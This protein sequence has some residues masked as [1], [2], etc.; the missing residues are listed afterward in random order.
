MSHANKSSASIA[1]LLLVAAMP[2]VALATPGGDPLVGFGRDVLT[3]LSGTLGPVVFG[4]GLAIA[5]IA[6]IMGSR[7]GLQKAVWAIVGGALLFGVDSVINFVSA[8]SR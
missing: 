8:H 2:Q 1:C 6:L 7:D 4:I 3:F 5:A